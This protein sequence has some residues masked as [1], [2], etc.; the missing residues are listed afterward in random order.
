MTHDQKPTRPFPVATHWRGGEPIEPW[1]AS[2]A[3]DREMT[4]ATLPCGCPLDSGCDSYHV[5]TEG[6]TGI[7][8]FLGGRYR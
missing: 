2:E 7:A 1:R 6:P 4:Q 3:L 8:G 5:I